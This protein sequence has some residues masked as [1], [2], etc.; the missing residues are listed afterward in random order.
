MFV[1]H[2]DKPLRLCPGSIQQ[3]ISVF[4]FID[5]DLDFCLY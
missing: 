4:A 5:K 3:I 1:V 2:V